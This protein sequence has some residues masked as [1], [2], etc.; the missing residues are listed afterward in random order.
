MTNGII[1]VVKDGKVLL[2]IVAGCNGY[3]A[4]KLFFLLREDTT[5]EEA[6]D[7]AQNV[8]L[9][10]TECLVVQTP[11]GNLFKGNDELNHLYKKKFQDPRFNPRWKLGSC[12][13]THIIE[14]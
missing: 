10:C 5:A 13:L 12:H 4:E 7:L 9:G 2:K 3:N 11:E 14:V 6:Y 8:G 1:A